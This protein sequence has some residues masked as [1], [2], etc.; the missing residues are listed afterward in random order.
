[1]GHLGNRNYGRMAERLGQYVP[2]VVVSETLVEI[3]KQ[4]VDEEQARLCSLMPLRTATVEKLA[5]LWE[6]TVKQ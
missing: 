3:L 4:L 5:D 6:M 1:M 2:G